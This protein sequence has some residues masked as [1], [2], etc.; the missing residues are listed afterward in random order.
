MVR[1]AAV[2]VSASADP[3]RNRKK[4]LRYL[5]VASERGAAVVCFPELFA[6]PWFLNGAEPPAHLVAEVAGPWLAELAEHCGRVGVA[7]VFPFAERLDNGAVANAAGM[8]PLGTPLLI[9]FAVAAVGSVAVALKAWPELG[10]VLVAYGLAAL[11][12]GDLVAE[13]RARGFRIVPAT[14]AFEDPIAAEEPDTLYLG[15]GRIA[16]LAHV[17][18]W[19]PADLVSPT[20][21]EDYLR[22]RFEQEV[23]G[24]AGSS[25]QGNHSS[26]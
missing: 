24:A 13:L 12:V 16:A 8:D 3:E 1:V 14:Q 26:Q 25:R 19:K 15:Q 4:A 6:A 22:R 17:A 23:T 21:D 20:E 5:E 11:F 2:Q 10:R 7:G 9:I 18:G